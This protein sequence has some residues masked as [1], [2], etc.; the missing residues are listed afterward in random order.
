M[1]EQLWWAPGIEPG[2]T[3]HKIISF[4]SFRKEQ[5]KMF[6]ASKIYRMALTEKISI[7]IFTETCERGLSLY[8]L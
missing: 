5:Q 8:M 1:I 6:F 3:H 4:F 2:S 7:N